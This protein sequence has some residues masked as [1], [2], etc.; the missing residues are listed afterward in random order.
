MITRKHI[1]KLSNNYVYDV[2]HSIG[3]QMYVAGCRL[4][5][6]LNFDASV[7]TKFGLTCLET[8]SQGKSHY[9]ILSNTNFVEK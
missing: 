4:P 8:I 5:L 1:M 3:P 7:E 6:K 2:W 9:Q